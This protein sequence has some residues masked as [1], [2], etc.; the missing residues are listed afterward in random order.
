M[1][2]VEGG[3]TLRRRANEMAA[4]K[5]RVSDLNINVHAMLQAQHW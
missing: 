3:A 2:E 1:P 4:V 5:A